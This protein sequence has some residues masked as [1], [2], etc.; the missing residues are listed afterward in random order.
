MKRLAL[1]TFHAAEYIR[2]IG[3][4]LGKLLIL[5]ANGTFDKVRSI[6]FI[7]AISHATMWKTWNEGGHN[8]KDQSF[9]K[10]GLVQPN[11]TNIS[12]ILYR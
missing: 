11:L 7:S 12:S 4:E 10:R 5:H 9:C 8:W 3:Q 2:D 1:I 6:K